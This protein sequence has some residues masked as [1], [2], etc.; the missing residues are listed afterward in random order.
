MNVNF[1]VLLCKL[2][3][4]RLRWLPPSPSLST[5]SKLPRTYSGRSFSKTRSNSS[6]KFLQKT[7]VPLEFLSITPPRKKEEIASALKNKL[8][9]TSKTVNKAV[10]HSGHRHGEPFGSPSVDLFA[11]RCTRSGT[12]RDISARLLPSAERR[13]ETT[14]CTKSNP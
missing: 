8:M 6:Y 12:W 14:T 1:H 4:V 13:E 11:R 10:A 9:A 7:F 3:G 2:C 5:C